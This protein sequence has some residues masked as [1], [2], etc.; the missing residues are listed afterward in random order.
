[1]ELSRLPATEVLTVCPRCGADVAFP[2]FIASFYEFGTFRGLR[3]GD[4]YRLDSDLVRYGVLSQAEALAP[5]VAREGG[6]TA[7]IEMPKRVRCDLCNEVFPGPEVG[8]GIPGRDME[9][10]AIVLPVKWISA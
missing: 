8:P 9:V 4:Y 10:Q 3:T 2:L 1:M 6:P 7:L 5:A